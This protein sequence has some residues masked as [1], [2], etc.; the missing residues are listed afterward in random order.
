MRPSLG[1]GACKGEL[2]SGKTVKM[3]VIA[4]PRAF[5]GWVKGAVR[6]ATERRPL[7]QRKAVAAGDGLFFLEPRKREAA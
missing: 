1:G 7:S 6:V 3:A 2:S 5:T 4:R